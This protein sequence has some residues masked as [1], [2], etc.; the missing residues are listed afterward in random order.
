[1]KVFALSESG[2]PAQ[3]HDVETPTP[4]AGEVRVRV[5]AASLN[6]FDL[7]VASGAALDFMPHTFPVVV[8]KDFA[9][10][11]DALGEG[12]DGFQIGDRVFGV[13]MKDSL[14]DGSFGEYVTVPVAV[15]IA[16]LPADIDFTEA[17]A[18]GLA[19]TAATDAFD[20][21]EI[22]DG[23]IVLIA[24]ATGGVGQ[25]ALQL[26]V[27]AGAHVIATAHS[28]EEIALVKELGAAETVDYRSDIAEQV[29][30]SHAE[31]VDVVL[32]FAG[33][34]DSVVPVVKQGGTFVST[35]LRSAEDVPVEGIKVVS[36]YA[37]PSEDTLG[38]IAARHAEKHTT[39]TVQQV[40][41]LDE[42]P[43]AI[44]TFGAGTLGKLV[45]AI[46]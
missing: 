12:V 5:R 39:V 34:P 43:A 24:G 42:V 14:G 16:K 8:G 23:A 25:Q 9:G 6:G 19:G 40:F 18:L 15:G 10:E 37:N 21:A 41:D 36:V 13:V 33:A 28:D 11:V 3:I 4:A 31:G 2:Q 26:A 38:R 7:G 1:M 30:A 44:G 35:M 32:H 27:R 46:N 17:A 29:R 22:R 45:I 20:A